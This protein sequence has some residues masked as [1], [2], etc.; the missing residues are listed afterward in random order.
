MKYYKKT[1]MTFGL[2]VLMIIKSTLAVADVTFQFK[3]IDNIEGDFNSRGWMDPTSLFQKNVIAAGKIWGSKINSSETILVHVE[4]D[5]TVKRVAATTTYGQFLGTFNDTKVFENGPLTRIKTGVN[6]QN[7]DNDSYD[8]LILM[9]S[10]Y[11]DNT[12]W[13]DPDPDA[14]TIQVPIG[15][16]DFVGKILHEIGHGLGIHGYR[17]RSPGEDYGTFESGFSSLFDTLTYF[18]NNDSPLD[19]DGNPNPIFFSGAE[20]VA[21]Y[22]SD[23][24]ITHRHPDD[25]DSAGG[26]FYHVSSCDDPSTDLPILANSVMYG[27]FAKKG[28]RRNITALDLAIISDLGYPINSINPVNE[29]LWW[30]PSKPGSGFDIGINSNND[31]YMIW[32]TYTLDGLPIWYLASAPLNGSDWNAD[33]L[34]FNRDANNIVTSKRVGDVQ[35]SFQ[36]ST[37]ASLNWTLDTGNGSAE[38]EHLEFALGFNGSA[39]TWFDAAQPG[40]GLTQVNQGT[41]QVK[42]LYFYDE[43]GNPTWALG[44]GASTEAMTAMDTYTGTCPACPFAGSVAT[45]AGTVTTSYSGQLSGVLSTNINLLS[46]LLGS[47]QIFEATISNLSE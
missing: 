43:A 41:S 29:G 3:F 30:I 17:G 22:G 15:K 42:V 20:S 19:A 8:I 35:L 7:A 9:N 27:C 25:P 38:I 39:G 44:S 23:I 4:A 34:E 32:Y 46:P 2:L 33:V 37:H 10:E 31:L 13:F 6:A 11:A 24:P 14:R 12:C 18:S 1:L 26:N 28:D 45:A 21:V 5:N 16:V 40:Y 47:W 36:D